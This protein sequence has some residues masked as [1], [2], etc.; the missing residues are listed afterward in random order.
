MTE[1]SLISPPPTD[2]IM[3][4][5]QKALADLREEIKREKALKPAKIRERYN[6]LLSKFADSFFMGRCRYDGLKDEEKK[7][8]AKICFRRSLKN[9]CLTLGALSMAPLILPW[10]GKTV[11]EM[12]FFGGFLGSMASFF[13]CIGILGAQEIFGKG[14][15]FYIYEQIEFVLKHLSLKRKKLLPFQENERPIKS[16]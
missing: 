5:R 3:V 1:E 6:R 9:T 12:I 4:K 14:Y 11:G 13:V 15:Q 10:F 8:L 7:A 2:V 16:A